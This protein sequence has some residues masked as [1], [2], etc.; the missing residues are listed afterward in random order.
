MIVMLF[1]IIVTMF[2]K[3]SMPF[4]PPFF[5]SDFAGFHRLLDT[6]AHFVE[7]VLMIVRGNGKH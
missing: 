1:L 7:L 2:T 3:D 6:F 5:L 4:F